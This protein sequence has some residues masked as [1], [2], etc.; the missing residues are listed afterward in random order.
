MKA[1]EHIYDHCCKEFD[2][3]KE[4]RQGFDA[5]A[6]GSPIDHV[7]RSLNDSFVSPDNN[8][9]F[10]SYSLLQAVEDDGYTISA[11]FFKLFNLYKRLE[12]LKT[13]AIILSSDAINGVQCDYVLLQSA[14]AKSSVSIEANSQVEQ[15]KSVISKTDM[16]VFSGENTID[17]QQ[18]VSMAG[19]KQKFQRN[20]VERIIKRPLSYESSTYL[21]YVNDAS[22]T[23]IQPDD[24]TSY[25][26]ASILDGS[27]ACFRDGICMSVLLTKVIYDIVIPGPRDDTH[28]KPA[29]NREQPIDAE[30]KDIDQYSFA[31]LIVPSI[32]KFIAKGRVND[33]FVV[34]SEYEESRG[35]IENDGPAIGKKHGSTQSEISYLCV[36]LYDDESTLTEGLAMYHLIKARR[37]DTEKFKKVVVD[38]ANAIE[39]IQAIVPSDQSNIVSRTTLAGDLVSRTSNLLDEIISDTITL[40]VDEGYD[41]SD[42]ALMLKLLRVSLDACQEK[43]DRIDGKDVSEGDYRI[44]TETLDAIEV[45]IDLG[46]ILQS[47]DVVYMKGVYRSSYSPSIDVTLE[48]KTTTLL[49]SAIHVDT[50]NYEEH[51]I[52]WMKRL[53]EFILKT[54]SKTIELLQSIRDYK[55]T[56]FELVRDILKMLFEAVPYMENH[57]I[58]DI[59][60]S[61]SCINNKFEKEQ[62]IV[63]EWNG[64]RSGDLYY[65]IQTNGEEASNRIQNN[66]EEAGNKIRLCADFRPLHV[67]LDFILKKIVSYMNAGREDNGWFAGVL[68][69]VIKSDKRPTDTSRVHEMC[70]DIITLVYSSPRIYRSLFATLI[71]SYNKLRKYFPKDTSIEES[72]LGPTNSEH[73]KRR[74]QRL[75]ELAKKNTMHMDGGHFKRVI[76]GIMTDH[77]KKYEDIAIYR[78]NCISVDDNV[79]QQYDDILTLMI[80]YLIIKKAKGSWSGKA[81]SMAGFKDKATITHALEMAKD[82]YDESTSGAKKWCTDI[83]KKALLEVVVESDITYEETKDYILHFISNELDMMKKQKEYTPQFLY[84]CSEDVLNSAN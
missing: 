7:I 54:P 39:A 45:D 4:A 74:M 23:I 8:K 21:S 82:D 49:T 56:N 64:V 3:I 67:T 68:R 69:K 36:G 79:Y 83:I 19:K 33:S 50:D 51:A 13:A 48:G 28:H 29:G 70:V 80:R 35:G 2:Q 26:I 41:M 9:R 76:D 75:E 72:H 14:A 42:Y 12:Y 40:I 17:T 24:Y 65:I 55:T 52:A 78:Y 61:S 25:V 44:D 73:D 10:R 81:F 37:A 15:E 31:R 46:V 27:N 18:A 62:K 59:I 6:G 71:D 47:L 32:C 53:K 63:F 22:Q 34:G 84:G 57:Q 58:D 77:A 1:A 43:I 60:N 11:T 5:T 20:M 38:T 30:S 16:I 66:S